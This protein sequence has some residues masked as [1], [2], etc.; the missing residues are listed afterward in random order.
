[1]PRCML[2]NTTILISV[3]DKINE[4]NK[5]SDEASVEKSNTSNDVQLLGHSSIDNDDRVATAKQFLTLGHS[6]QV[7]GQNEEAIENYERAV[8]IALEIEHSDIT[9]TAYQ[10]LGRV[11]TATSKYKNAIECYQKARTISPGF[12]ADEVEVAAYQ[13]LGYDCQKAGHYHE[14]IIYYKQALK[15]SLESG[16]TERTINAYLELGSAFSHIDNFESSETYFLRALTVSQQVNDKFLQKEAHANLGYVYH[17][18]SMFEAAAES[19]REVQNIS[20]ELGQEKEETDAC[21]VLDDRFQELMQYD[22]SKDSH[23]AYQTAL[24]TSRIE[25]STSHHLHTGHTKAVIE[26]IQEVQENGTGK[27]DLRLFN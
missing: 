15:L 13:W 19:Y 10:L 21:L 23:Y 3:A 5:T 25:P 7:H 6:Y 9:A 24:E 12:K 22:N 17:K 18:N 8:Q 20:H 27:C 4:N 1:M 26:S 11:H 14:S 2:F 16:Y